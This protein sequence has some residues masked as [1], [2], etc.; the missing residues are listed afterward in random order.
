MEARVLSRRP[1][2]RQSQQGMVML[3][4]LVAILIF[5]LGVLAL[6][7]LQGNTM[8][9]LGDNKYRADASYLANELI[10]TIWA[11]GA[12]KPD[13]VNDFSCASPCV[14]SSNV[15]L[16]EWLSRVQSTLPGVVLSSNK[17]APEI[18]VVTNANNG[19]Q[20]TITLNW[21]VPDTQGGSAATGKYEATAYINPNEAGK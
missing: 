20:V 9:R 7:A 5:S 12:A 3:E 4:S 19:R 2:R 6:L 14:T 8:K 15:A 13:N 21:S 1:R 11:A 16:K 18:K 17:N 10:G